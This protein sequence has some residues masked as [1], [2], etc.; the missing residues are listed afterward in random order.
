MNRYERALASG[1]VV[2]PKIARIG[3]K[4]PVSDVLPGEWFQFFVHSPG[5][6]W[7]YYRNPKV[8]GLNQIGSLISMDGVVCTCF[9]V[10][11]LVTIVPEPERHN[12]IL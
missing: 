5:D 4:M 9:Y 6:M 12:V 2:A 1:Q 7:T 11:T 8:E 10:D 3:D